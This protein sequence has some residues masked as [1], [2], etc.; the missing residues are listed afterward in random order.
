MRH[1][2]HLHKPRHR[3]P[4]PPQQPTH[5]WHTGW[6][7]AGLH[8][9]CCI[10]HEHL[11]IYSMFTY[12]LKYWLKFLKVLLPDGRLQFFASSH[13]QYVLHCL[14]LWV[15]Q[16]KCRI[17]QDCMTTFQQI[18]H[19]YSLP[20]IGMYRAEASHA[21]QCLQPGAAHKQ[22]LRAQCIAKTQMNS[23][24]DPISLFIHCTL[25]TKWVLEHMKRDIIESWP[26]HI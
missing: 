7:A 6:M 2:G 21:R 10:S 19:V 8:V 18:C 23:M 26:V 11:N 16:N 3:G 1:P 14:A 22:M 13:C 25:Y 17:V 5:W 12:G 15:S 20:S 9:K 24:K 4:K